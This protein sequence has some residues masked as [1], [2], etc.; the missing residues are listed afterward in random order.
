MRE[1]NYGTRLEATVK[2]SLRER[3]L[4][5]RQL[6][7]LTGIHVATISKMLFGKQRVNPI[8]LQKI[9]EQLCVAPEVSKEER[10]ILGSRL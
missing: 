10:V 7:P 8:Q 6:A 5:I 1:E 9:A 4:S 3:S 2:N